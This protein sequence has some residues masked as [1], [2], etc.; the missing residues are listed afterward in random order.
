VSH[1]IRTPISGVL[2]MTDLLLETNLAAEQR[3]FV[4]WIRSGGKA[5]LAVVNGMLDFSKIEAGKLEL[6]QAPFD[7]LMCI[8]ESIDMVALMAADRS[9]DLAYVFEADVPA[10][11]IGDMARLRQLLVNLLSNALRFT[12]SGDVLLTV[13]AEPLGEARYELRFSIAD[14]GIGIPSEQL[15]EIFTPFS[16]LGAATYRRYGG[17]GLGLAISRRLVELMGGQI[18]VE[19]QVD[20]GST[21]FFTIGAAADTG[22]L[23]VGQPVP[24]ELAGKR[25]LIVDEHRRS[26]LALMAYA[27]AWGMQPAATASAQVALGW[28]QQAQAFDVA[29]VDMLNNDMPGPALLSKIRRYYDPSTLPVIMME[30]LGQNSGASLASGDYQLILH[31]PIRLPQLQ[32]A[33][34]SV[35]ERQVAD[36]ALVAQRASGGAEP[37]AEQALR[38]LLA[39]D[40][41]INRQVIRHLLQ[42]LGYQVDLVQDGDLAL[43]ALERRRYDLVLLDLQMPSLDG[44]EVARLIRQRWPAEQQPYLV[45]ITANAIEGARAMCL[46][47]GMDDYISKPLQMA[48]LMQVIEICDLRSRPA[49]R[50]GASAAAAR[51]DWRPNRDRVAV[52]SIP[53][54]AGPLPSQAATP[55]LPALAEF[56][57]EDGAEL[58]NVIASAAGLGDLRTV[59]RAAHRLKSS[60]ALVGMP[61]LAELCDRLEQAMRTN[62]PID[63]HALVD[64][65]ASEFAHVRVLL[66]T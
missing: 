40:D 1:E 65:I 58:L 13:A 61:T 27:E 49:A 64:R 66:S 6:E 50:A 23:A 22:T 29:I 55:L 39:E 15:Q 5:L 17:T 46:S 45:A 12:H 25:I 14:T 3:D 56:Y 19:S 28:I 31:K 33:L 48:D 26:R 32:A 47:A 9:L 59:E 41:A 53:P 57:L 43:A 16:Q 44:L 51:L 21:F 10:R 11:L 62:T 20:V 52:D 54:Q 8:E 4:A 24:P 36:S 34:A 35:L 2:G 30:Q 60:S 38:L 37:V 63:L 7:L 42:K 18:W